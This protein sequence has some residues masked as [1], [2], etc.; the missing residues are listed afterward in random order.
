MKKIFLSILSLVAFATA[1]AQTV[2]VTGTTY[3]QDFNTLD[4]ATANSSN[5][6]SGWS[7]F[8]VGTSASANGMYRSGIGNS[9]AGDTYSFGSPASVDRALGSIRST[10]NRMRYGV[11]FTNN[12]GSTITSLAISFKG[13]QW[14]SGDTATL[15]DSLFMEYSTTATGIND[16]VSSWTPNWSTMFNS[17]TFGLANTALDGNLPANQATVN[18]TSQI[19]IIPTQINTC[20]NWNG[21]FG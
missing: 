1:Q 17:V 20:T 21:E 5:L 11:G 18:G 15:A 19:H 12:T 16:T 13:E 7:I 4:S 3:N 6:P 9:N 8:E 2:S 14:R 10:T